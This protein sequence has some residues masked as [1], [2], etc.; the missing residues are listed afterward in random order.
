MAF[1][2]SLPD[3]SLQLSEKARKKMEYDIFLSTAPQSADG[4]TLE[5]IYPLS[6]FINLDIDSD[7]KLDGK[8]ILAIYEKFCSENKSVWFSSESFSK[9][10]DKSKKK[11]FL[12]AI[13]NRCIVEIFFA[14]GTGD[15]E[16]VEIEYTA[17]I[18]DINTDKEGMHSPDKSLTPINWVDDKNKLWIQIEELRPCT[19]FSVKDF[20]IA[21]T[22]KQLAESIEH[23]AFPFGYVEKM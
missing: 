22:G 14:A 12:R 13:N 5:R 2:S 19:N 6:I 16:K 7:P 11:D 1:Y 18:I 3:K 17:K 10:M 21:S 9:G 20:V 4:D 15:G 8:E 23:S